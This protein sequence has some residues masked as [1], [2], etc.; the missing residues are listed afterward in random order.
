MEY[1]TMCLDSTNKLEHWYFR[2]NNVYLHSWATCFNLYTGHLQ[3]LLYMWVH[4][5]LCTVGSHLVNK[6]K[7][8]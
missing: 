2:Q 1:I 4:K 5:E 6:F 3:A 8:H 7:A